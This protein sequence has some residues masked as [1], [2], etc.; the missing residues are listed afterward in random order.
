MLLISS[1][2]SFD[3]M[4]IPSLFCYL[5][6]NTKMYISSLSVIASIVYNI[7]QAVSQGRDGHC[8]R[9]VLKYKRRFRLDSSFCIV[10][11]LSIPGFQCISV[12]P[13]QN[14]TPKIAVITVIE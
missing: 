1:P 12:C 8:A 2:P 14:F 5:L 13:D 9:V 3:Q 4:T 10:I 7:F 11:M 6:G